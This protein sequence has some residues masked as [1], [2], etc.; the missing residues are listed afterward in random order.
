VILAQTTS[1]LENKITS[2][3]EFLAGLPTDE[4]HTKSPEE[5]VYFFSQALDTL[6][7]E[8]LRKK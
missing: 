5:R 4:S 7:K 6:S 3:D 2:Y 1:E 8:L